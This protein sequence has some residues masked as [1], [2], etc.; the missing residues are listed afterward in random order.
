MAVESREQELATLRA[1]E[2]D[3]CRNRRWARRNGPAAP[4]MRIDPPERR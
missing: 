4:C 1:K 2:L 3:E